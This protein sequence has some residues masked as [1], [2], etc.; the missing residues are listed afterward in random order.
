MIVSIA[1]VAFNEEDYLPKLLEDI[2]AQDYPHEKTEILLI[3]SRSTDGT[4]QLMQDFVSLKEKEQYLDIRVFD[5]SGRNIPA[6][7]NVALKNYVGD[8]IIRIDAHARM[9]KEFIRKN[10]EILLNGEEASGGMRPSITSKDTA[11]A[12]TLLIA[13]NSKFGSGAASYRGSTSS[14][15]EDSLFCGMYRREVFDKVGLY[16]ERLS[17][18]ED[19]EMSFRMRKAGIRLH[20]D[21][22]IVYYQYMRS[23][24]KAML[25][26]KFGNG[27]A[28]SQTSRIAPGS[29]YLFHFAPAVFVLAVIITAVIAVL[30]FPWLCVALWG[31]YFLMA[32]AFTVEGSV[33]EGFQ[34]TNLLLPGI[35][36]VMH[37]CYGAGTLS[38]LFK[39]L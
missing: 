27:K 4:L 17:R 7:S 2:L 29:F 21:P 36:L 1:V 9:P 39:K 12:K 14:G 30:G 20:Y 32:I 37:V 11:W 5:N 16:D 24:L 6:G 35:F 28:V 31:L 33:R 8:A 38:G 10:V 34:I 18:S 23:S 22:D 15:Y 3:D 26:Q 19:N 13:E 25:K